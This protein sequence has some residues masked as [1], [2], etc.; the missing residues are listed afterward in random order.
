MFRS[1]ALVTMLV[2]LGVS[3]SPTHA[4]RRGATPP[5]RRGTPAPAPLQKIAP[6]VTCPAP[7]GV[8]VKSK[9]MYCDVMTARIPA[10]GILIPIPPHT[11]P[12]TLTF[13]LHN[14]HTYSEDLVKA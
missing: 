12:V 4:Q 11:G 8:G 3:A 5:A 13:D 9:V 1:F 10:E 14:R 6:M 7:L 2:Q